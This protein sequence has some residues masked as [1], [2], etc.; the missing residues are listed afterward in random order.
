MILPIRNSS[1]YPIR[2]CEIWPTKTAKNP[3]SIRW[4]LFIFTYVIKYRLGRWVP[5]NSGQMAG[6]VFFSRMGHMQY[7]RYLFF[8]WGALNY[9]TLVFWGKY[10]FSKTFSN[11]K[12]QI[13]NYASYD[14]YCKKNS[15]RNESLVENFKSSILSV[16]SKV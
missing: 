3:N 1:L 12:L 4:N 15:I 5:G 7:W 8:K 10:T 6:Y 13:L 9:W 14:W 2:W 11:D 16:V